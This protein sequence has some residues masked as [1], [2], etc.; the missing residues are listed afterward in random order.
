MIKK[1]DVIERLNTL[2]GRELTS[3]SLHE[4]LFCE[5]KH[6]KILR[7]YQAGSHTYVQYKLHISSDGSTPPFADIIIPGNPT[8]FRVGLEERDMNFHVIS[9]AKI[10]FTYMR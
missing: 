7:R 2:I 3:E 6:Q 8:T 10:N 9:E 1:A 5:V 4:A